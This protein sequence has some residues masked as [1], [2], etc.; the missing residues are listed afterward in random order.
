MDRK[1]D[2]S[3]IAR[4]LRMIATAN[5]NFISSYEKS[6][7]RSLELALVPSKAKP[8]SLDALIDDLIDGEPAQIGALLKERG[9][10]Y[11]KLALLGFE[12]V[13]T[14]IKHIDDDRL[15]KT[16]RSGLNNFPG[17][18]N[19][20]KDFVSDLLQDLAGE[21]LGAWRLPGE[22]L[23][24]IYAE[25]WWK[26]AKRLGEETY[27]VRHV[28]GDEDSEWPN[29]LMLRIIAKKYTT[30]LPK[31]YRTILDQR[32]NIDSSPVAEAIASSSLSLK[33]K[34]EL[35]RYGTNHKMAD[36]R[37]V[38]MQHLRKLDSK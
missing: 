19:R 21:G 5:Q 38:A 15:T 37:N 12:A 31:I 23:T 34:I 24:K 3:Q 30:H 11:Q 6:V 17:Y 22:T 28:L 4:H 18:H 35:F 2:R 20:I 25:A 7:L 16:H 33:K 9:P 36:H 13:P 1:E 29:V 8:G 14:L 27:F 26:K 10:T 32:Q